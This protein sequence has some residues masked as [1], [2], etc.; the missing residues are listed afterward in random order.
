M[1]IK[2]NFL[3]LIVLLVG[4]ISIAQQYEV[5]EEVKIDAKVDKSQSGR[6]KIDGVAAVVGS[7]VILESD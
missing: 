6:I 3:L 1:R 5:I 2:I 7:F 4:Q